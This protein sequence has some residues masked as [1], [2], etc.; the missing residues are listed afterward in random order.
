MYDMIKAC[1][2]LIYIILDKVFLLII[3][4]LHVGLLY[5]IFMIVHCTFVTFTESVYS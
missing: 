2:H 1:F 5:F 4:F 3:E